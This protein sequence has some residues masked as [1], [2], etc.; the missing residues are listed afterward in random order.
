[1]TPIT[2]W[3][4]GSTATSRKNTCPGWLVIFVISNTLWDANTYSQGTWRQITLMFSYTKADSSA[5][6]PLNA[7]CVG[8][9]S[10]LSRHYYDSFLIIK[11]LTSHNLLTLFHISTH[12]SVCSLYLLYGTRAS[13]AFALLHLF[14]LH[15]FFFLKKFCIY[16]PQYVTKRKARS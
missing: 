4:R 3:F 1:M 12:F 2:P 9:S 5:S 15:D 11:L 10:P 13:S 14:V 8:I 16:V 7:R 6:Q